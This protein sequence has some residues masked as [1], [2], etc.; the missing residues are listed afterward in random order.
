VGE[1]MLSDDVASEFISLGVLTS[2][3]VGIGSKA[4]IPD[5]S[6]PFTVI[7]DTG[8][9]GP[10]YA[11]DYS[12]RLPEVQVSVRARL[13]TDARTKALALRNAVGDGWRNVTINGTFYEKITVVQEVMDLQ[14]DGKGRPK[15]GFNLTSVHE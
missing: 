12:L 14:Q 5:G 1:V 9:S 11:H 6:T 10:I 8:G 15:F 7:V 2:T 13:A 3:T 4:V